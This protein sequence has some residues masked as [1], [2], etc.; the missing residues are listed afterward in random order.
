[1]KYSTDHIYRIAGRDNNIA[2]LTL[3]SELGEKFG[4]EIPVKFLYELEDRQDLE[5]AFKE[6]IDRNISTLLCIE[7]VSYL[8]TSLEEEAAREFEKFGLKNEHIE[9]IVPMNIPEI[10]PFYSKETRS[11]KRLSI[12]IKQE[13]KGGDYEWFY[14]YKKRR[15]S[16]GVLFTP[17]GMNL[18]YALKLCFEPNLITQLERK[19][20]YKRGVLDEAIEYE[21]LQIKD[22]RKDISDEENKRKGE[23]SKKFFDLKHKQSLKAIE[24]ELKRAGTSSKDVFFTQYKDNFFSLLAK[25]IRFNDRHLNVM[26]KKPIFL[27]RKGLAHVYIRHVKEF[28]LTDYYSSQGK[29]YFQ[30]KEEDIIMVMSS[31]IKALDNEIQVYWKEHPGQEYLR[32]KKPFYFQGDYYAFKIDG[33]GKINTFYKCTRIGT[34]EN[35][36]NEKE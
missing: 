19:R 36:E 9:L 24:H 3:T 18:Y 4:K 11:I 29:D 8:S 16:Q 30:W 22:E 21:Y 20:M 12:E 14:G 17:Y 10:N 35:S 13:P 2:Y 1:M 25:S 7:C 31:V 23:L 33:M 5:A 34:D 28:K 15:I 32:F 26:G 27:D 6:G